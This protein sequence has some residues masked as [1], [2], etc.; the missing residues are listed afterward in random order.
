MKNV[1]RSH[2]ITMNKV[3]RQFRTRLLHLDATSKARND[4]HPLV[5]VVMPVYNSEAYVSDAIKSI[6]NQTY[7]NL[8]LVIVDDA[9]TDNSWKIISVFAKRFPKKIR[10]IRLR[11]N[12]NKGGDT[13]ANVGFAKARG[14]YLARMDAD[15]ISDRER[16][17][18]QVKFLQKNPDM[19]MVGT[20]AYVINAAGAVT[21]I[22]NVPTTYEDIYK[23]YAVFHPM[24]HPTVMF[25]KKLLPK[26]KVIYKIK[27]SANN[28]LYTFFEF[29]NLG[30]FANLTEKLL[31]Y[32][33][34]GANDS[35]TKPKERFFNTLR[36]RIDAICNH[37]Y[38][39]TLKSILVNLLQTGAILVLPEKLIVPVYLYMKGITRP[40][41]NPQNTPFSTTLNKAAITVS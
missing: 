24:I 25:N 4:G 18:K 19:L 40:T 30:K 34:H 36:I 14:I 23:N 17:E 28:D 11:K 16:I 26:R 39:P 22:K 20:Q 2:V 3:T 35:L 38:R 41:V 33:V 32:R 6:V 37:D 9:S 13:C 12:L 10:A 31:Y 21:G 7:Q 1:T 29:L 5:S 8:E 15:D 27:Y